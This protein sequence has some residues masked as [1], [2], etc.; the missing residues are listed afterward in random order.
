MIRW[1]L[2]AVMVAATL[3]TRTGHGAAEAAAT[4]LLALGCLITG[5]TLAGRAANRFKLPRITGHLV[6]GMLLG[7]SLIALLTR[8][9]L[10]Q[11]Q[12]F[13]EL[14]LGLI[15]L[16]AGGELRWRTIRS[17]LRTL[18]ALSC[19]H[20]GGIALAMTGLAWLAVPWLPALAGVSTGERLAAAALFGIIAVA[21]S[22]STTIAVITEQRARGEVVDTVLGTTVVKDVAI[23]LA[24]SVV[25]GLCHTWID[26]RPIVLGD[27]ATIAGEVL[28]SLLIGAGLGAGLGLLLDRIGT[29]PELLVLALAL[30]SAEIGRLWHAEHLLVCIAAGFVARNVFSRAAGPLLDAL[31]QSS[32]PIY[33]VFF[34]LVGASLDLGALAAVWPA[35]VALVVSRAALLWA[36]TAA[37]AALGHAGTAVARVGWMGFVAQAGVSLGLASRVSREFGALGATVAVAV[38]AAVVV[39]QLAGPVLWRWAL[40]VAGETR[41]PDTRPSRAR[42]S[43]PIG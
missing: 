38:V 33:L 37:G 19:T 12:L 14:A 40:E 18:A 2:F 36:A 11:L 31:E 8:H 5:G 15:A 39:N 21:S 6:L 30:I 28:V 22:P 25:T 42:R 13:E 4:S 41:P 16:T 1:L 32:P 20:T 24:F 3:V 9:D 23:L 7:P 29:H 35:A 10:G 43:E 26:G 17:R 34:V 27:L